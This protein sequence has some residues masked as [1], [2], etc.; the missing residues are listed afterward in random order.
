MRLGIGIGLGMALSVLASSAGANP[1]VAEDKMVCKRIKEPD[2]GSHFRSSKRVCATASEW[3]ERDAELQ[4]SLR[5][6]STK[7]LVDPNAPRVTGG[8]PQ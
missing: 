3:K 1:N 6:S 4:R 2:T 5:E 7:G 8:S